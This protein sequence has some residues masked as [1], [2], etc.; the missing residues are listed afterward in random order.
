MTID[1]DAL[2]RSVMNQEAGV[3]V[4]DG[5]LKEFFPRG[6]DRLW[7]VMIQ[8][9]REAEKDA[10]IGKVVW[11]FVDRMNDVSPPEDSAERILG[12]FV[13]AVTP[14]LLR[15]IDQQ[16]KIATGEDLNL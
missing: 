10:E 7:L 1:L 15:A 5:E 8:R 4:G 14:L 9:L 6:S 12:E 2:E 11:R 3:W 16:R 13:A